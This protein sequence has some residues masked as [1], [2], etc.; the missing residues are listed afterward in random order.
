[1]TCWPSPRTRT[2]AGLVLAGALLGA[3]TG[4]VP[5]YA[6]KVVPHRTLFT[7]ADEDI[8]ESSGL[9]DR[10]SRVY[11]INDSGDDAVVYGVDPETGET[12]SRTTYAGGVA[13]V[14]ALAPGTDGTVWAGDIGDNARGRDDIAV[15]QVRPEDG[16]QPAREY[17]L[18]Y[19]DGAHDAET[20]LVRPGT[21]RVF[22]VTKSPFGGTVY[23][24]PRTLRSGT[25]NKLTPYA[26][27]PGLLTDGTFFPDGRHV[28]LRSYGGAAVYTF[29]GFVEVGSVRLPA[30]R[31]GEGIAVSRSGRVL[32]SSEG[33]RAP[34]LQVQLPASLTTP[35]TRAPTTPTPPGPQPETSSGPPRQAADWLG[36][37]LVAVA[38]LGLGV[39]AVRATRVT[40]R[41][42]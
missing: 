36:I 28:L 24:A 12:V 10:G 30:Q 15:Y 6:D 21:G 9:V 13:D 27:V 29:P 14:E 42:H 4:A 26:R 40:N 20:L 17:R 16:Q 22:V 23:A 11:T 18:S 3:G 38:V 1:M 31:Q 39:A 37:G 25:V 34:V 32:I 5:A 2:R 33:V 7:F 35:P 19:P 41:R 8:F